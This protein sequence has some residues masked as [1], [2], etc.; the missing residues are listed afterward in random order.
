MKKAGL[1]WRR[2][3]P[4]EARIVRDF[5]M[6]REGR[7]AAMAARF[8]ELAACGLG[9]AAPG[10]AWAGFAVDEDGACAV[11]SLVTAMKSGIVSLMLDDPEEPMNLRA[12]S[13]ILLGRKVSSI[14]GLAADV[15]AAERLRERSFRPFGPAVAVDPIDYSLMR[16][17]TAPSPEALSA[18]PEGLVVRRAYG[19]DAERIFPLQAAY[20]MEEVVPAGGAFNPA[21]ARLSLERALR[22]RIILYAAVEGRVVGKAGTNASAYAYDQVGGVF[23]DP[24]HRGRGIATRLVA[25]LAEQL[26]P[27][28]R[29]IVLFVK[30]RNAAAMRAYGKAGFVVGEDYRITYFTGAERS[31]SPQKSKESI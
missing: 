28:G 25:E 6:E 13:R 7:C 27:Q 9:A 11:A 15:R 18:G 5:L 8:K 31:T 23:V 2:V 21:A 26:S 22:E 19:A 20:E 1:R 16:L 29:K 24:A 12:L 14:Q 4:N 10:A 17:E 30:K 3:G